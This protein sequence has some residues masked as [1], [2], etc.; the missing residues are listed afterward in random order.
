MRSR[1]L[2]VFVMGAMSFVLV[3]VLDV[4]V[5]KEALAGLP[6]LWVSWAVSLALT[7]FVAWKATSGRM[8]WGVLSLING[9]ISF[10]IVLANA[11]LPA[12]ASAPYEP[13][14]DWLRS[15]D[16]IPPIVA[17]L[18]EAIASGYFA[19]AVLVAGLIYLAVAYLLLHLSDDSKRHAH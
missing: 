11:A 7:G 14:S 17:R 13:G 6:S 3:S 4:L 2:A 5:A 10:A 15:V 1:W 12:L 8:A 9:A 18:R 16:L 19:I